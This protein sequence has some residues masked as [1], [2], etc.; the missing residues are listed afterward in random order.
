LLELVGVRLAPALVA[1]AIL[2]V[3]TGQVGDAILAAGAVIVAGQVLDPGLRLA[4]LMPLASS[5]ARLLIP[6]AGLALVWLISLAFDPLA[7]AALGVAA[8]G[9]ILVLA[10]GVWVAMRFDQR[11]E[12]RIAVAGPPQI[13]RRLGRELALTGVPGYKIVGWIDGGYPDNVPEVRRLGAFAEVARIVDRDRIDLI[14]N[15]GGS[16]REV[17]KVVAE[18]CLALDVR[19]STVNQ[20]QE[21][22]LGEISVETMDASY[23]QYLMHPNFRAGSLIVKRGI[24]VV[25]ASLALVVTFPLAAVVAAAARLSGRGPV[26][27]RAPRVGAGGAVFEML[28]LRTSDGALGA[29]IRRTHADEI[30]QLW[31]VLRGEMS[32]VGP[33]PDAP[34]WVAELEAEIPFYG[35]RWFIRPGLTGWAQIRQ[36]AAI[37]ET[38][39]AWK[40][41]HDL[42]YLK[43]RSTALDAMILLQTLVVPVHGLRLAAR[44][45]ADES[46]ATAN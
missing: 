41:S 3:H 2:G 25:G 29:A 22:V 6:V 8:L 12:I 15:T 30:P 9:A 33:R 11:A 5:V 1:G 14:V 18:E 10:L 17:A 35:R 42:F 37:D 46:L 13:A 28:R 4:E 34:E 40:L 38:D 16:Q 43:H 24:D 21:E 20:L 26:L 39:S 31:N 19:L 36:A 45:T 27:V 32:L 44:T 23:F 7:A